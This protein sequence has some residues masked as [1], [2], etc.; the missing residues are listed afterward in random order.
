M[1]K[2]FIDFVG[3]F[4]RSKGGNT[5]ILVGVDA[6]LKFVWL[7]PVRESTTRAT[8][9]ALRERIFSTFSVPEKIVSDNAQC[10][11]SREFRHFCFEMGV[12]HVTTSPY[13]PQPSHAE[14][15]NKNLRAALIAYHR[16]AHDMW[17]QNL[18]WL[19]LAFNSA[20]HEATKACPFN[21]MFPFKCG[22]PLINRWSIKDLLPAK[23]TKT[24][25]QQLWSRVR[26]N[27]VKSRD[28]MELRY[29]RNRL[30]QPFKVGDIVYYKN[31][32]LSNAGRHL[33]A[34]LMPRYKGPFK[35]KC[36]LTPVTVRLVMPNSNRFVTRAHVSQLKQGA[37]PSA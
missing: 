25:L 22:S 7:I 33:T 34:K 30:P 17:D 21:V 18:P 5:A 24:Q 13:Y 15:F 35:I 8:I 2:L 6:F 32:P 26:Q 9:K 20:E 23:W 12:K 3:R 37:L 1:E 36:F 4:P 28:R 10:F 31:H 29:N 14:R 16:E 19:Q 11:V 27:L